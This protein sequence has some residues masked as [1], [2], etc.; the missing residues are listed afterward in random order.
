VPF[1]TIVLAW[2]LDPAAGPEA[3]YRELTPRIRDLMER[4]RGEQAS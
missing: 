1:H 2:E 4:L 3:V